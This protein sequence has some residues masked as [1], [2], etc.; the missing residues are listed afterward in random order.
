M[1]FKPSPQVVFSKTPIILLGLLLSLS[2]SLCLLK[3]GDQNCKQFFRWAL[4][5]AWRSR[6]ASCF[7]SNTF[8]ITEL[9]ATSLQWY[10][11]VQFRFLFPCCYLTSTC[12]FS[13][14]SELVVA[15]SQITYS[16]VPPVY[17]DW[18]SLLSSLT[19][20]TVLG[21]SYSLIHDQQ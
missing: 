10:S 7:F 17:Q 9:D 1:F 2:K 3:H 4:T 18:S 11:T 16:T 12:D 21:A 20:P 13:P 15:K 8:S 19:A 6:I 14:V 5:S